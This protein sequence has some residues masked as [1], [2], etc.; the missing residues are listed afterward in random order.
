MG[1]DTD[2]CEIPGTFLFTEFVFA[3]LWGCP[4]TDRRRPQR[5]G[6]GFPKRMATPLPWCRVRR[7][8]DGPGF[9]ACCS[10]VAG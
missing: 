7:E 8:S 2:P 10:L 4:L 3:L 1:F 9:T 6:L 5:E